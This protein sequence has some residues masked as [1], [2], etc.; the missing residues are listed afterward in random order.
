MVNSGKQI[1]KGKL[2]IRNEPHRKRALKQRSSELI[3][4]LLSLVTL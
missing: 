3:E 2:G 4:P 1:S